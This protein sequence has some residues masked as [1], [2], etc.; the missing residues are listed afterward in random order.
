[1]P[2][3]P[4]GTSRTPSTKR[5]CSRWGETSPATRR[6]TSGSPPAGRSTPFRAALIGAASVERGGPDL[7]LRSSAADSWP[8]PVHR[9]YS[10]TRTAE[11]R[12]QHFVGVDGPHLEGVL[13]GGEGPR[14]LCAGIVPGPVSEAHPVVHEVRAAAA[15]RQ[16][17]VEEPLVRS[18]LSSIADLVHRRQDLLAPLRDHGELQVAERR[19]ARVGVAK[20]DPPALVEGERVI[21]TGEVVSSRNR[22]VVE[23]GQECTVSLAVRRGALGGCGASGPLE[24]GNREAEHPDRRRHGPRAARR[25]SRARR[26]GSLRGRRGP[27]GAGRAAPIGSGCSTMPRPRNV[28]RRTG[29]RARRTGWRSIRTISG[30]PRAGTSTARRTHPSGPPG[31]PGGW[32]SRCMEGRGRDPRLELRPGPRGEALEQ[33]EI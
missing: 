26:A 2:S 6:C 20:E 8:S 13:A 17:D 33:L 19:D 3:L 29:S 5:G 11:N 10:L 16:R 1:M 18:G 9:C 28:L 12:P 4:R 23:D 7:G 14:Q 27:R 21:K 15:G 24:R 31:S 22:D 30:H 25:G 32:Q